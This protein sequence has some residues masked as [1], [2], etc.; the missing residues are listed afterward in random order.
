[1]DPLTIATYDGKAADF[2]A[3]QRD[4]VPA[5]LRQL[6]KAHFR[7]G[8]P[9]ADIGCG[10]GRDTAW[11]VANGFPTVGYEASAGMLAEARRAYPALDLRLGA[12]PDLAGVVDQCY[13]NVLCSAVVMHLPSASLPAAVAELARVTAP[14][15][16]LV[17]TY[18]ASE[19][20]EP[21]EADGRLYSPISAGEL[22]GL[23][24]AV[25]LCV[26]HQTA[27]GDGGRPG[28]IWQILV[29]ERST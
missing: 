24:A 13:Q 20:N 21:R 29:A 3:A 9:T 6:L 28:V 27:E 17:L 22:A 16:R 1:M 14:T 18:R 10:S 23:C 12:L 25:G 7:P 4:K 19:T 5:A 8:A 15:G 2:A 26:L 11:L